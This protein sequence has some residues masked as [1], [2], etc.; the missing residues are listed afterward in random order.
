MLQPQ[1]IFCDRY[2]LTQ[3]LANNAG[4][5]TWLVTDLISSQNTSVIVKLLAFHPEMHWD[6][7]KLFE[8]EGDVLKQ[9]NHPKIPSYYDYFTIEKKAEES[10]CWFGLVQEYIPGKTLQQFLEEGKHFTE[11]Q[12]NNIAIQILEILQYLHEF[13]PPILH[14]DIKPSNLIFTEDEQIF[15]V[16][17]GAVQNAAAIEGVTFTVVGTTGYAPLEQLWGKA[18]PA[19][20]LY[21]LG[22]TLI[23]LLTGVSPV[24]L[25]QDNLRIQF[26]DRLSIDAFFIKWINRLIDPDLNS[27]FQSAEKA[28]IS[29]N[30]KRLPKDSLNPV[31]LPF[32]S[33]IQIQESSHQAILSIPGKLLNFSF[34]AKNLIPKIATL[35]LDLLKIS[36]IILVTVITVSLVLFFLNMFQVFSYFIITVTA[37]FHFLF[38]THIILSPGLLIIYNFQ[39]RYRKIRYLSRKLYRKFKKTY[40]PQIAMIFFLMILR[41]FLSISIFIGI[42]LFCSYLVLILFKL[43]L[44]LINKLLERIQ[45]VFNRIFSHPIFSRLINNLSSLFLIKVGRFTHY[46]INIYSDYKLVRLTKSFTNFSQT[47]S[48]HISQLQFF[49]IDK[50]NNL[51]IQEK[52]SKRKEKYYLFLSHQEKL[53]VSHYLN[54]RL[55]TINNS[56]AQKYTIETFQDSNAVE[57]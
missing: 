17:F 20:D 57:I 16:D 28:L 38:V 54:N 30:T 33:K 13:S 11:E 4:R 43:E 9:L 49:Y 1:Q 21:G 46:N 48:Y 35:V 5:Q 52:K 2:Q 8:R 31:V 29:L 22:A 19:S 3:C 42:Y 37:I 26:S 6:D 32:E 25:P 24:N 14:R 53:W 45:Q 39:K 55:E 47:K 23:H 50:F 44:K 36:G 10:L 34:N 40:L 41:S 12:V 18:V 15:L 51:I 7:Y 56:I 27:R